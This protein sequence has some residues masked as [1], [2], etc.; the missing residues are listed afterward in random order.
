MGVGLWEQRVAVQS[1]SHIKNRHLA[2]GHLSLTCQLA[3]RINCCAAVSWHPHCCKSIRAFL[4]EV[5]L[6]EQRAAPQS[7]SHIKNR[8]LGQGHA[9]L[10]CQLA[11]GINSF[12]AVSR[13]L[14]CSRSIRVVLV[15]GLWEQRAA[16]QSPNHIKN[17]H[18]AQGHASLTCQLACRVNRCATVSWVWLT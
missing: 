15:V 11:C 9:S 17:R 16:A 7:P 10:T 6:W 3:C 12:A 8:H 1:P 13:H 14:H 5:G 18:L 2:Q 4:V